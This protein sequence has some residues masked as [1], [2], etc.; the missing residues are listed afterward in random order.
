MKRK[1]SIVAVIAVAAAVTGTIYA[2][3]Q[4][5]VYVTN[6]LTTSVLDIELEQY[7]L[8]NGKEVPYQ[9]TEELVMPGMKLSRIQKIQNEAID[10]YIRADV[11]IDS[12]NQVDRPLSED[13]LSGFSKYWRKIDGYYYYTE[14][15]KSKEEIT[16]FDF[17]TIPEEWDTKLDQKGQV[18]N[19]YTSNDWNITVKVDAIQA[20]HFTPNFESQNPWG[21]EGKDFV[22]ENCLHEDGYEITSYKQN[23]KNDNSV[24]FEGDS[25]E[26][27]LNQDDFFSGFDNLV[28]GDEMNGTF[29]L[30]NDG[31]EKRTFYFKTETP[32]SSTLLDRITLSIFDGAN[33]IYNGPLDSKTLQQYMV[34]ATLDAGQNT[35]LTFRVSVPKELGNAFSLEKGRVKWF[36]KTEGEDQN[37]NLGPSVKTGDSTNIVLWAAILVISG[38]AVIFGLRKGKGYEKKN[39]NDIGSH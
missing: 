25:Q 6:H 32:E 33:D 17:I 9:D 23:N 29:R 24:V 5:E 36:F 12:L 8:Q 1:K 10:C 31:N 28:P 38:S 13:D 37:K 27:I 35:D 22:V 16:F 20:E 39:T 19:Y 26:L 7:T 3:A 14:I 21:I 4:S 34:L 30:K 18:I 15:L 2:M 11:Q